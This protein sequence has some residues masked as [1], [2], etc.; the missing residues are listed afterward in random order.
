MLRATLSALQIWTR[1]IIKMY[2]WKKKLVLVVKLCPTLC[3]PMDY[4]PPGSSVHGISQEY[5]SKLPFPLPRDLPDLEIKPL[6]LMS[7]TLA[8][9]FFTTSAAWEAYLWLTNTNHI[10]TF[11]SFICYRYVYNI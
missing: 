8:G 9:G 10:D 6:S 4:S 7:P 1:L 5:W 3:D 2:K 11:N